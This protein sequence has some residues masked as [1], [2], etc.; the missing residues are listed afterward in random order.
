MLLLV[1]GFETTTNL[2]GNAS[3]ALFDHPEVREG[4]L[5]GKYTYP[6]FIEEARRASTLPWRT[7]H[8]RAGRGTGMKLAGVSIPAGAE[9]VMLI[10]SANRGAPG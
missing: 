1:A 4:L 3:A 9:L 8:R 2:L 10:G 6:A 5:T 7:D